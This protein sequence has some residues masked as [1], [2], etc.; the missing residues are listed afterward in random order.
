MNRAAFSNTIYN[1]IKKE[2]NESDE[3]GQNIGIKKQKRK[4]GNAKNCCIN[5]CVTSGDKFFNKRSFFCAR[6][7]GINVTVNIIVENTGRS[8]H[9]SQ[10]QSHCQKKQYIYITFCCK[11]KTADSGKRITV[12]NSGFGEKIICFNQN[13]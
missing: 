12:N 2:S 9:K 3:C 8:N 6:H 1:N 4:P 5:K 10:P 7:P 11:K 13:F